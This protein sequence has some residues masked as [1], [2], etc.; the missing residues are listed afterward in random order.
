MRTDGNTEAEFKTRIRK[1]CQQN[2]TDIHA[3]SSHALDPRRKQEEGTT[4]RDVEKV[5]GARDEGSLV[6]LAADRPRWRSSV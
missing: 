3:K 4:N 1:A 5:R 6:E 2:A